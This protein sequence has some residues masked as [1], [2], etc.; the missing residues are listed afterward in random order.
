MDRDGVK[1]G[2]DLDLT[3]AV[4]D[5]VEV[6]VIA[7]GGVGNAQDLVDGGNELGSRA[8]FEY[9]AIRSATK[10]LG[11]EIRVMIDSDVND[12]CDRGTS[13]DSLCGVEA[14]QERHTD[15]DENYIW[16]QRLRCE[17][18]RPPVVNRS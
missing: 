17:N 1:S 14:I 18:Q 12:F 5:A 15:V 6:P 10:G 9:V 4:S 3:R 2:Y 16:G 11:C 7:S 8:A 13:L